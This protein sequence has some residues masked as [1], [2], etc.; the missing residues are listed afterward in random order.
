MDEE[1][2]TFYV[3]LLEKNLDN[4]FR[5]LLQKNVSFSSHYI[6]AGLHMQGLEE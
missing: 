4:K 1:T 6:V 5:D 3:I 2:F